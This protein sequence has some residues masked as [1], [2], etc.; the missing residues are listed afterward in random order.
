MI[1]DISGVRSNIL[2][3]PNSL[4]LQYDVN[5]ST[6]EGTIFIS[7]V[8]SHNTRKQ[9]QVH[10]DQISTVIVRNPKKGLLEEDGT[11]IFPS[12]SSV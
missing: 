1:I 10:Y 9:S 4:S 12:K 8:S 6:R 2:C 3:K 11:V 5:Y 7:R